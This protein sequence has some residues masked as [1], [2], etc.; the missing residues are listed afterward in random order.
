MASVSLSGGDD[1][2]MLYRRLVGIVAI[3]SI[4]VVLVTYARQSLRPSVSVNLQRAWEEQVRSV[5]PWISWSPS[6][7]RLAFGVRSGEIAIMAVDGL[8]IMH[9][10]RGD[11]WSFSFGNSD[12]ELLLS[13]PPSGELRIQSIDT[14]SQRKPKMP[15]ATTNHY[16]IS[17]DGNLMAGT[18]KDFLYVWECSSGSLLATLP[19][20]YA[21]PRGVRFSP[22]EG[23]VAYGIRSPLAVK[24]W[25]VK[26]CRPAR[27]LAGAGGDFDFSPDGKKLAAS[28]HFESVRLWNVQ[29]GQLLPQPVIEWG[30][31]GHPATVAYS[32]DGRLIASGGSDLRS[33]GGLLRFFSKSAPSRSIG[34]MV[35]ISDAQSGDELWSEKVSTNGR[36]IAVAFS[37]DG[38]WLSASTDGG[39]A[40]VILWSIQA[41]YP[42]ASGKMPAVKVRL[43]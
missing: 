33:S 14:G 40:K 34:G 28:Y 4:V 13:V 38:K 25:D 2:T 42:P 30:S 10:A 43:R 15:A 9:T 12:G 23:L 8:A 17:A 21:H 29:T 18:G 41:S 27:T 22:A 26:G 16:V 11:D 3:T 19:W 39:K 5:K 1:R 36:V 7:K 6:G 37:P 35:K 20:S 31:A 24:L 32:P